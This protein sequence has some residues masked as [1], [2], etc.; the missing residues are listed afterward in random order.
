VTSSTFIIGQAAVVAFTGTWLFVVL[1]FFARDD[2]PGMRA[3][4]HYRAE[5]E[6]RLRFL[7]LRYSG[8]WIVWGQV[9]AIVASASLAMLQSSWVPLVILPFAVIGPKLQIERLVAKR[10]A[11][12]EG[13]TEAWLNAIANAL[14][15]SP[16]LGEAIAAS[17]SLLPAPMSQEID[18]L[19]KEYEL[20]TSLD[21]ALEQFAQRIGSKTLSGAVLALKI[22]RNSGGNLPET[23][24]NA[25]AALREMARLE[26][27]VRT[28]TAEGKAQAFVIGAIPVP[29]VVGIHMM[30]EHFFDALVNTFTGHLLIATALGLWIA[31]I[32]LSLKILAV[33]I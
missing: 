2:Q 32:L 17:A 20:G 6:R 33:D 24:E 28:K 25:A 9:A 12:L 23:L 26:G 19:V 5:L 31:A 29:M 13:L 30:D 1:F 18:L 7:R 16:S 4:L 15:A 10:V 3:L 22:A 14:K 21:R 8:N 27:V 11:D